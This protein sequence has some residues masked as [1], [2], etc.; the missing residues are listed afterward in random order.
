MGP[1]D[2]YAADRTELIEHFVD[3]VG[4]G[5]FW[6]TTVH[7]IDRLPYPLML[8][9][10]GMYAFRVTNLRTGFV[11]DLAYSRVFAAKGV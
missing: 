1:R 8:D 7:D 3:A 4:D 2:Q 11:R 10:G 9:P 5:S 6:V